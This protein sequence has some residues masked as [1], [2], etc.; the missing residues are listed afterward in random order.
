MVLWLQILLIASNY[1]QSLIKWCSMDKRENL[2]HTLISLHLHNFEKLKA[3]KA[4]AYQSTGSEVSMKPY[5]SFAT[6]IKGVCTEYTRLWRGSWETMVRACGLPPLNLSER[7]CSVQCA[8]GY[9]YRWCAGAER[10]CSLVLKHSE[11]LKLMSQGL[12]EGEVASRTRIFYNQDY[13]ESKGE[14]W[15]LHGGEEKH[16]PRWGVPS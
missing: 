13:W 10:L 6:Q 14:S 5:V 16:T 2:N 8:G 3:H 11:E 7:L 12:K 15:A 4:S 1:C 9:G